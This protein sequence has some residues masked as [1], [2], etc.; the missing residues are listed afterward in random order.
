[1][2]DGES[3]VDDDNAGWPEQHFA[4]HRKRFTE[5]DPASMRALL[6]LRIAAQHVENVVGSW[7]L[8]LDLTPQ[9]FGVLI[10]LQAEGR[11]ISLSDL[12]RYLGTTQA[13]VTGLV[14][15]LERDGYIERRASTE[16][17]RV[18]Y[19]SLARAGKRILSAMLPSYFARNKAAMKGL[20]QA[21]KKQLLLLLEKTARGFEALE[22]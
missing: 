12:R 1:M 10:V 3:S 22:S 11:P 16:D 17:R 7:F 6:A 4:S 5:F 13:N 8:D 19:I 14:A 18:S 2:R 15:G 9:K 21:E 20:T